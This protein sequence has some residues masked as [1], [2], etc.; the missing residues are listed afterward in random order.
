MKIIILNGSPKGK[1]SIT[2]Q[3]TRYIKKMFPQNDFRIFHI[4]ES[5]KRIKKDDDFFK[6]II[7]EIELSDGII[8][9]FGLWILAVPAQQM[10][11]IELISER[12][13]T[14]AFKNKYTA[15]ISTSIHFYDHTAHKYLRAVCE[16]MNMKYID[17]ISFD[18]LD[19]M[20]KEKREH[21]DIF[22]ENFF[23]SINNKSSSSRS[24]KPLIFSDFIYKPTAPK[25]EIDTRNQE[26][27]IL[28][29]NYEEN[30]NI[31]RMVNRF[32]QAFA[33]DIEVISLGDIEIKGACLGCMRCGYDNKCVYKD[34]FTDFYNNR[35]RT[36]DIIVFAGEMKGRYLSS[37]WKTFYDRAFF[38]NHTPSLIGKQMAYLISGPLSQNANLIEILEASVTARQE[39]N[40]VDIITDESEKSDGIDAELQNLANRLIRYSEKNYI[41][42]RDFLAEGGRKIFRD[43]IWGRLRQYGRQITGILKNMG[44][45]ISLRRI[46][47]FGYYNFL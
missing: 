30:T 7:D 28:T 12:G 34:G 20:K 42:P 45:M 1:H 15:V 35:V 3:Y 23:T 2:L 26:V 5:I 6:E 4:S 8:W 24:F 18:I 36:A 46:L 29:D 16:D 40:F 27:L 33:D 32:K 43:D 47:K 13:A 21:L 19:L 44:G 41:K 39:A 10:R 38:W 11:F 25:S 22:A 17:G 37:Q 9:S 14:D 31:N